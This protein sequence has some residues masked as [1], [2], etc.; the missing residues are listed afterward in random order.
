MNIEEESDFTSVVPVIDDGD[1]CG[2]FEHLQTA[3]ALANRTKYLRDRV[4]PMYELATGAKTSV[5]VALSSISANTVDVPFPNE[6]TPFNALNPAGVMGRGLARWIKAAHEATLG[7]RAGNTT[8][9]YP[10]LQAYGPA[11]LTNWATLDAGAGVG[12]TLAQILNGSTFVHFPVPHPGVAGFIKE[13]GLYVHGGGGHGALPATKPRLRLI[14]AS[15]SGGT[16]THN[17]IAAVNDGSVDVAAYQTN[18]TIVLSGLSLAVLSPAQSLW[19]Y[20]AITGESGANSIAGEFK[21]LGYYV[22]TNPNP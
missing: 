4:D 8:I 1:T 20:L 21:I 18:H 22:V 7:L 12:L 15:I 6:G 17:E 9:F 13:V 10:P 11:A 3:Q 16:I 2:N 19:T 14:R 5:A